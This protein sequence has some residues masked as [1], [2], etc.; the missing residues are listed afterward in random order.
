MR[1]HLTVHARH[2]GSDSSPLPTYVAPYF[3]K[4]RIVLAGEPLA[5]ATA[6][7]LRWM[8]VDRRLLE[9]TT[10]IQGPATHTR[11]YLKYCR[12]LLLVACNQPKTL[13]WR[14][15]VVDSALRN[16]L[17]PSHQIVSMWKSGVFK[18]A[19]TELTY[20]IKRKRSAARSCEA[21]LTLG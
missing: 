2:H 17:S 19:T 16:E 21:P 4:I 18:G 11:H 10:A 13:I 8:T 20:D 15:Q 14:E 7:G 9:D 12:V 3:K 6:K 5:C 1:H